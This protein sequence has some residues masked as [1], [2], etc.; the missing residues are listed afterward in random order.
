MN[1]LSYSKSQRVIIERYIEYDAISV[2]YTIQDGIPSL[3]TMNDD[4][5]YKTPNFGAVNCGGIYPS[6]DLNYYLSFIDRKVKQ[7]LIKEDFKNGVLFMQAFTNG[8]DLFFFEMGYRLS[9]GRHYILQKTKI[10]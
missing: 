7:M 1:N 8:Q 2:S 10:S 4:Y 6:K 5:L 3:S 9:G